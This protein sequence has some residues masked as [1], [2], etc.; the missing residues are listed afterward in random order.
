VSDIELI[1]YT[2][3]GCGMDRIEA[4]ESDGQLEIIRAMAK[5][6]SL[7]CDPCLAKLESARAASDEAGEAEGGE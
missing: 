4:W 6:G 7:I 5:R 2:C 1:T 3:R